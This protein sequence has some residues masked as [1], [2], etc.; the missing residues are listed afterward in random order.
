MQKLNKYMDTLS[1]DAVGK[2]LYAEVRDVLD[3]YIY[4]TYD[5]L[6]ILPQ[7]W[8]DVACD[9]IDYILKKEFDI[10]YFIGNFRGK[11]NGVIRSFLLRNIEKQNVVVFDNLIIKLK[12]KVL[13]RDKIILMFLRELEFLDIPFDKNFYEFLMKKSVEFKKLIFSLSLSDYSYKSFMN[14]LVKEIGME[15]PKP[16]VKPKK[17]TKKICNIIDENQEIKLR[18]EPICAKGLYDRFKNYS[19]VTRGEKE[20]IIDYLI[21]LLSTYKVNLI[22]Y[23]CQGLLFSDDS[24]RANEIIGH[25]RGQYERFLMSGYLPK[26]NKDLLNLY[27]KISERKWKGSSLE[28]QDEYDYFRMLDLKLTAKNIV[29]LKLQLEEIEILF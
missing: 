28:N 14:C 27:Q 5:F 9:I 8:E 25:I 17:T 22:K 6:N 4:D 3:V 11:L 1:E 19:Y 15:P 7:Q 24:K 2:D 26:D 18:E 21:S 23:C 12:S 16:Q 10:K 13:K 20:F 29:S